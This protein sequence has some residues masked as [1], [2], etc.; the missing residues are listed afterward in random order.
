LVF[1][2]RQLLWTV[3]VSETMTITKSEV[4]WETQALMATLQGFSHSLA[5]RNVLL[6]LVPCLRRVVV[7]SE[8]M[9][10]SQTSRTFRTGFGF[11]FTSRTAQP[12]YPRSLCFHQLLLPNT[13]PNPEK[14]TSTSTMS[15]SGSLINSIKPEDVT[16]WTLDI[17]VSIQPSI[18][19]HIGARLGSRRPHPPHVFTAVPGMS[20]A[21]EST[22]PTSHRMTLYETVR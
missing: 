3:N 20:E 11:A 6:S 2:P 17:E 7:M 14:Q 8:D 1:T 15:S 22:Q 19:S 9:T 18:I 10:F 12:L 4:P 5:R 21:R 16:A 13:Q